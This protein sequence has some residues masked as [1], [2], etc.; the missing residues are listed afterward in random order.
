MR[1]I[2]FHPT[3]GIGLGHLSRLGAIALAVRS[4][5]SDVRVLFG[6]ETAHHELIDALGFP[7]VSLP[8]KRIH[9]AWWEDEGSAVMSRLR[10]G[11]LEAIF[12]EF[13]P[14]L[15]VFDGTPTEEFLD[16]TLRRCGVTAVCLRE[17]KHLE[18]SQTNTKLLRSARLIIVPA[19]PT[20]WHLPESLMAKAVYVG[21]IARVPSTASPIGARQDSR[22]SRIRVVISG[23]GGGYP[24]TVDFYNRAQMAFQIC[25]RDMPELE[26]I[27]VTGPLFREW[28]SLCLVPGVRLL[29]FEADMPGLLTSARIAIVQGGYNTIAELAALRVPSI[30]VPA[31]RMHDDQF[32]RVRHMSDR[33]PWLREI[34]DADAD[35]IAR[36]MRALIDLPAND[37]REPAFDSSGAQIAA[38]ALWRLLR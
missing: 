6:L 35:G 18:R 32:K 10:T 24:G 12:R 7:Y 34:I 20:D 16:M 15:T 38:E 36:E 17:M 2:L 9:R 26:G 14:H 29:P 19:Q 31:D 23:G 22:D 27:L 1:R 28:L 25:Q 3:N 21:Q 8:S 4:R 13:N 5:Y 33:L 11:M 37:K 30:C